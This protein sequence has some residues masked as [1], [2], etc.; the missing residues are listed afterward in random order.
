MDC[1]RIRGAEEHNLKSVD[2]D[3]PRNK[4]VVITGLSG[5]GKSSLAFDT[6]YQEGQR[7]FM[8]SL[9]SYA[10]QFL[11]QMEKPRVARVD[12]LSPTLS[13]DQKTVNRNPRSTVGTITELL[14]HLR[15]LMARLGTPRCPVCFTEISALSAAQIADKVLA[16]HEGARLH[17]MAP[18][19]LDRKGEYRKELREALQNGFIRARV[20]GDLRSLEENIELARYEKHTIELVVDR[21][22]ARPDKRERLVEAI[23]QALGRASGMVTFLI[24]DDHAVFSS[25]RTCPDHGVSIPE[26]EPRLFSFNAPQGACETCNGLGRLED[27]N[28]DRLLDASKGLLDFVTVLEG[29]ARLPFTTLS[30]ATL[31]QVGQELGI[32]PKTP[33]RDLS[34]AHQQDLLLGANVT[35]TAERS[36][37]DGRRKSTSRIAW[38]GVLR[39][40]RRAWKWSKMN[41]LA[42]CRDSVVCPDCNGHRLNPIARAVQFKGVGITALTAMTISEARAFFDSVDLDDGHD[43]LVGEPIVREIRSRLDFLDDVGLGYLSIDRSAATLSG[44]E[45]QR[46]RLASQVGAGLQGVTYILD[47]PSIGLHPSDLDRLLAALE[48]LRDRGNTVLVVEHDADTMM[49]AD[50]LIEV[51]PGAGRLGGE[52]IAAG[53]PE[54]FFA[55]ASLTAQYLRGDKTIAIPDTRRAGS[56]DRLRVRNASANNLK[57]VDVDFPLGT[58]T[59]VTG[60]SGSGKST[61]VMDVLHRSLAAHLNRAT[62][63]PGA[64][65]TIE[66]I[67]HIDKVVRIDQAPIGRTPRSNPATY[68]GLW[69]HVRTLFASVSESQVRGYTKSRFS[70]NVAGGRCESCSG[71][72][73][74]TIEM[75]FLSDVEVPCDICHGQRF[76]PE[77]LEIRYRGRTIHDILA[78]TISEAGEFFARHRKMKRILD[79]LNAVGLGYVALGQ[80][81]TTLSGGEAQRIKLA[82]ELHRPSTGRTF[83][84]LDEP[85]TGL[86]MADV[87]RLL[88]AL[89]SL[90]DRGNTVVVIEHNTDVIKV[91][92][93]IIEMGPEGGAAGGRVIATGTPEAIAALDTP[94]GRILPETLT[95]KAPD[96]LAPSPVKTTNSGS[97]DIVLR[98]V[99]THNLKHID[100]RFPQGRMSVVTGVSGSGKS[101]LAFHTLFA[102]GQRRY[103]ESLS[104]YARRFLGR[105]GRA[106]LED[107]EGLAPAIAIDQRNRSHNPR[108][109][110]ATVT[111]IYD[112][113]RLLYARIGTPHCPHCDTLITPLA[114]SQAAAHLRRLA[115]GSGWLVTDIPAGTTANDLL[116]DGYVRAWDPAQ[117]GKSAEVM[118]EPDADLSNLRLVVDRLNP[119]T[120][121][122]SRLADGIALAYGLGTDHADFIPR[123]GDRIAMALA[124]ECPNHGVI[125]D[126]EITPRHFSFNSHVGACTA[127]DGLG[128]RAEVDPDLILLKPHRKLRDA[129][130]KRVSSVV[131]RSKPMKAMLAALYKA[132]GFTQDTAYEDLP[133]ELQRSILYG[134]GVPLDIKWSKR[135]GRSVTRVVESRAW[136]G[137]LKVVDGWKSR[138][139]W[140]G[141]EVTCSVCGGGRL[142]PALLSVR[143]GDASIQDFCAMTVD[144]AVEHIK[145]LNLPVHDRTIAEQAVD[146]LSSKLSF[147]AD[148]GL[149]YLTLDRAADTLSGGES[150]R[151]RL[152]TQLGARLTGTIY[153]LDEP[154][155]GLHP[156]DTERLLHTLKGLRDLGN[157]LVIVEHDSEVMRQADHIVD[158]GPAAGEHGG[159]VVAEGAPEVMMAADTQTAEYLSGAIRIP[160]PA[161]RRAPSLWIDVP[162]ATTNNLKGFTSRLPRRCMTA[163]TGVSGSGKSSYVMGTIAPLLES[164]RKARKAGPARIVTVDQRPIGRSPRSTPASYTKVLDP[165]RTLFASHPTAIAMGFD[166]GRFTYNGRDGACPHCDGRGAVLVE[167]HFL[168]DIWVT[169]EHCQGRRFSESTLA[170]KWN[171]HSIADV[172]EMSV[173]TALSVFSNHRAI[174][175]RLQPLDDVGLG[176]LRLGQPADTLSGGEAQRLKLATELIGRKKETCFLLDEPTTGL[177]FA[178]V[179]KLLT[180][181]HRLVDAGHMVVVIEHHT[182]LINNAD[183][184]IDLGPDGGSEGGHQVVAGTPELVAKTPGSWTGRALATL[185]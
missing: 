139:T 26:M 92:D 16:D 11:G 176:Y 7:R 39:S 63:S 76:N 95:A 31:A 161:K 119:E 86:H 28:L 162:A 5:S 64:H 181:L 122:A 152:A 27:F 36:R 143:I 114:P 50:H 2:I 168:S 51:G 158:M 46:I 84:M 23:E 88:G 60:V 121:E 19:V 89:Q 71:A 34:V 148:V 8:E 153:V 48:A 82:T 25:A 10:R 177:H 72:G 91:A 118:L 137:L 97:K 105:V 150:Q 175:R 77:T 99:Y 58:F 120:V 96:V 61:L 146:D 74:K 166:K 59:A 133:V 90:V 81:S 173:S 57:N 65:D 110:V 87:D 128:R 62:A 130:D 145:H 136:T 163:I 147:L 21:L 106:P 182:E 103:V 116:A 123:N 109:T 160:K 142:R 70:F 170:V 68:T 102:E 167:M 159:T 15:L 101:S 129:L 107:A 131:F 20:D 174:A 171:G 140:I 29:D 83:Y 144:R 52:I 75:Q 184:V 13:I 12:G 56:G 79:T 117:T 44:G 47:E 104:T 149:G 108:S 66:G 154:T 127:C 178:D 45:A 6:I 1:I 141:A 3:I 33:F 93:H 9:S 112:T 80:T 138:S 135:W 32:D 35:Y 55:S 156:R 78:M 69:D 14:D 49:R 126:G 24:G 180:V 183:H 155:V 30:R 38:G 41:R 43:T 18:I 132:H 172:L 54:E 85:T 169:C 100:V 94:T 40:V 53:T 111:E 17:V 125:H 37:D 185:G 124:A 113:L 73:V 115:P 179:E 4:L 134:H 98:G 67:E 164:R 42:A 157:T 22:K 151:I 165:I